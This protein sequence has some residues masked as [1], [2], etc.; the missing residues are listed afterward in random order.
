MI[1]SIGYQ[2]TGIGSL[3]AIGPC[4]IRADLQEGRK[5]SGRRME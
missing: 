2:L 4:D 5:H 1:S 3:D